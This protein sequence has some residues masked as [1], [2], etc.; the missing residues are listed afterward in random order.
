M[1]IQIENLSYRHPGTEENLPSALNGIS[2]AIKEGEWVAII[3]AN[4]SGKTT[5]ARHINA[6]LEPT[7][8][9]VLV[10][11]LDTADAKNLAVI[12]STV[13][14]VFQSPE[15]QI[16]ASLVIE[17]T[18]FGPENLALPSSQI[19][20][21]V[22][23]ALK[24]VGMWD[25]HERPPHLLSA[26]QIQRVALAGVLA[27]QPRCIIFDETTAMLDPKGRGEVLAQMKELHQRGITILMITHSMDEAALAERVI[28]L[29]KGRLA[30]D[31]HPET[32]FTDEALLKR[33]RLTPPAANRIA[34]SIKRHFPATNPEGTDLQGILSSIPKNRS[35]KKN[36]EPVLSS[37]PA[38][39]DPLI[40]IKGLQHRYMAGTPFE[41]ESLKNVE[42]TTHRGSAH[43]VVGATGSGKSTLLQHLNGIYLPQAGSV[44]VGSFHLEE[45]EVDVRALR[46]FAGYVFQNPESSFF[47]QYVG[48]EIAYGPK[49]LHGREGLRERVKKAMTQVGLDFEEFKDR[50]TVTLSGG[51]KRKV[52][53]ACALAMEPGLLILDEPSAGLDPA[54][55]A[56]LIQ[57]LKSLQSKGVDIVISSHNMNDIA[58]LTQNVTLLDR[59]TSLSTGETGEVF[60][61]AARMKEAGL[62]QPPAALYAQALREKCWPVPLAAVTL[63]AIEKALVQSIGGGSG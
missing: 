47:E 33:C 37:L 15:D 31:G 35:A 55:R 38:T 1:F 36:G 13:G 61:D 19:N 41:N 7:A 40:E 29:D 45:Q 16:V 63:E 4:G 20:E 51:E 32:I 25:L 18:A 23:A 30:A 59:G 21:R 24:L 53:L 43:G 34:A 42:M 28:L 46:R 62:L 22:E 10:D 14:M 50:M 44:H 54:S 49:Q 9:E 5:L 2:F 12:R 17:D 52:A 48:D 58:E 3:G 26:G 56:N 60:N 8:G 57:T 39:S 11:G 6:L 27:M